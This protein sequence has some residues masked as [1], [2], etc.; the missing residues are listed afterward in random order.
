MSESKRLFNFSAGPA[1]L[2]I[3]V[4]ERAQ[5][6]LLCLPNAGASVMEISHRSKEFEPIIQGAGSNIRKLLNIPESYDVLFVQ[7]G[8]LLQFAMIPMNLLMGGTANYVVTGAWSKKALSEAKLVGNTRTIWDGN[9][10]GYRR[11]PSDEE[12]DIANDSA[13]VYICS[14]ETIEG[15]QY[16]V[17]PNTNGIPLVCDASSDIF[18]RPLDVTKFGLIY[19]CAQKNLGP[20]GVTVVIIRRDLLERSAVSVPSLLN[21]KKISEAASMLNTPPCFAIYI[22]KLV[23]DWLLNDIGGLDKMHEI[24]K[25]KAALLYSAIDNS[26]GY[27]KTHADKK[28]RSIM[29]IPFRLPSEEL[30]KKFLNSAKEAGLVTLG[31]HRSVGGLRA[32]IYNAMPRE[33]VA[34][35]RDFMLEFV[36]NNP[37]NRH[38]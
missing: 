11:K 27:Y 16:Q 10:T 5:R 31:G 3:P 30:D 37:Y 35:L 9:D 26:D 36:K 22:V 20:A 6:E 25:E 4:L 21:Y 19:A 14:N 34:T 13:Y 29:N 15:V 38:S 8:A 24:N 2:P 12:L 28:F 17:F 23:T 1:V 33:G 32:S 18:C 7:G